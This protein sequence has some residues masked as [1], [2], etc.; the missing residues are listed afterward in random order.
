MA[1]RSFPTPENPGSNPPI[2]NFYQEHLFTINYIG[3]TKI[4]IKRPGKANLKK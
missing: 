2:G 3:K 4:K 1:K